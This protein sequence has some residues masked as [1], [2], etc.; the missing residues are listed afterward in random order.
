MAESKSTITVKFDEGDREL[1]NE[2]ADLLRGLQP[3]LIARAVGKEFRRP[4]T[5]SHT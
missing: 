3:D 1:L 5:G 4:R 2:L